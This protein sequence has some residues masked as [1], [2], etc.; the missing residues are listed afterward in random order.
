MLGEQHLDYSTTPTQP[1]HLPSK[2]N[3]GCVK[4]RLCELSPLANSVHGGLA[5]VYDIY[6]KNS[7]LTPPRAYMLHSGMN[8]GNA[9]LLGFLSPASNVRCP[10]DAFT[11]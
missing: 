8:Y 1:P 11:P 5:K 2:L 6:F 7:T 10:T 9:L 3:S 4:S